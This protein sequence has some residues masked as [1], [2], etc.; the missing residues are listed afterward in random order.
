MDDE[1]RKRSPR[2]PSFPLKEALDRALA[3][4]EKE[5]RHAI[6]TDVAAQDIGYKD[7]QS[8]PSRR[9]LATLRQYGLLISPKDSYV[10]VSRQVETYKF[11]PDEATRRA[12][13]LEFFR[14]PAVYRMLTVKFPDRLPSDA[15]LKYEFIQMGFLPA[16]VED[17]VK[18]FRKSAEF[19]GA[20][21]EGGIAADTII[22]GGADEVQDTTVADAAE[23]SPVAPRTA[24]VVH[25]ANDRIPVRLPGGRKAVLEIPV[26]FYEADKLIIKAQVD[27]ILTDDSADAVKLPPTTSQE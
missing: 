16:G 9:A 18:I 12:M 13:L 14:A 26:P 17:E 15:A 19:S 11:A 4:H 22:D 5:G 24:A 21:T 2:S 20:Y 1:P 7:G 23:S 8:G 25:T 10:S 3:I 27:F 6:P